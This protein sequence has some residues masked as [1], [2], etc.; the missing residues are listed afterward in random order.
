MGIKKINFKGIR[1][2]IIFIFMISFICMP[3]L[4]KDYKE[5]KEDI[6][7]QKMV[8]DYMRKSMK[9]YHIPG[10]T[11]VAVK[12][13][14][15]L[16]KKGYGY[17]DL[18][19]KIPVEPDKTL[20]RIGSVTKL[21]TATAAMQLVE[22]GKIDLNKDINE[23]L[24]DFKIESKYNKPVT[25]ANLL[26]HTAGFDESF[27]N[28]FSYKLVNEL[29]PLE[30][31]LKNGMPPV[32][33]QAGEVIQ[34]SNHGYA[35][36]GY[37]VEQVSG[38]SFDKYVEENIFSPLGMN[39]SKYFLSS[40]ILNRTSNGYKYKNGEFKAQ[41][42]GSILVHPAGS[43]CSTADD[44]GKFLIA[45][46]QNGKYKNN[47]ILDESTA[48]T[49]HTVQFTNHKFIPGYAYGFYQNG[50]NFGI[51]E[52]GGDTN[53][54]AS[55]LSLYPEK[56]IGFFI[57]YNRQDER[58]REGFEEEF[59]KYFIV[60]NESEINKEVLAELKG[61]FKKFEGDYR[62][63]RS[64][65]TYYDK[66]KFLFF[67]MKLRVNKSGE[68]FIKGDFLQ[69]GDYAQ[70]GQNIFKNKESDLCFI[71][72]EDMDGRQYIIFNESV[73]IVGEKISTQGR[74]IES[75]IGPFFIIIALLGFIISVINLFR[76]NRVKYTGIALWA[77]RISRIT[78]FTI[79][80]LVGCLIRF[81]FVFN[82]NNFIIFINFI[83]SLI[84]IC[85]AIMFV[86]GV[87]I[88]KR[89]LM[90]LLNRIFY[91]LV[92]LA[93]IGAVVYMNYMKLFPW[94]C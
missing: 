58:L 51:I 9:E 82:N 19:N 25:M 74:I 4:A 79:L 13:G 23:Y 90:T 15:I 30:D 44:M 14:E 57:S 83:G 50:K 41:E 70:I 3:V 38:M 7:F 48:E 71:L 78:C 8:D 6:K 54:F 17:A 46:L 31:T 35:L 5:D 24:K 76:K 61:D 73:H 29:K 87:F 92:T 94:I 69:A 63:V 43:I 72:K 81:M 88:W 77:K 26:T 10:V 62:L 59:Y 67:K 39:E 60:N 28:G 33:R 18:D 20:F 89:G 84:I 55:L 85:S 22:Q 65:R 49:M 86:L 64:V 27:K 2:Y 37:I 45:H 66:I 40:E 75:F 93:A 16:L 36:I 80:I 53:N 12:D 52:H 42:L 11:L 68:L 1:W 47:R 21:F 91:N 34:Y 32:V 56:N